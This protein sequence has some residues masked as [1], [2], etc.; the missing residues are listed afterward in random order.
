MKNEHY[1]FFQNRRCEYFPCHKNIPAEDFNS[2]FCYCPL[3]TL[4]QKCGGNCTYGANGVKMCTDCTF[5]HHR[6]NYHKI[7][8]H[9]SEIMAVAAKMDSEATNC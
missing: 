9:F 4:G 8:D 3:Y 1:R 2:L 5:P 7:I 6:E